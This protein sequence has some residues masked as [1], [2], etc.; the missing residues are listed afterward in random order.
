MDVG[1]Q[2][3]IGTVALIGLVASAGFAYTIITSFIDTDVN[4]ERLQQV[5]EVVASNLVEIMNL[6]K[7]AKYSDTNMT[8]NIDVPSDLAGK[9]YEIQLVNDAGQWIVRSYLVTNNHVSSDSKIPLSSADVTISLWTEQTVHEMVVGL[10]QS[11]I[12]I[13][14]TVYGGNQIVV[15]A[16]P[17]WNPIDESPSNLKIGIGWIPA[18]GG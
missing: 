15:W 1:I 4:T 8:K 5:S 11:I 3:I 16:W 14:G 10:D 17:N 18:N 13:S 9:A 2:H 12:H 7:F 6:A